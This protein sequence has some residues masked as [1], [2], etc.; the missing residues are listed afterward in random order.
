MRR[1]A[2]R[3]VLCARQRL[4]CA[5]QE[6][7]IQ[8]KAAERALAGSACL[9]ALEG[10]TASVSA[11]VAAPCA[12]AADGGQPRFVLATAASDGQLRLWSAAAGTSAGP[13]ATHADSVVWMAWAPDASALATAGADGTLRLWRIAAEE[14]CA[15]LP[16]QTLEL[17]VSAL[18]S[19]CVAC[20][21][22]RHACAH[23]NCS[24][25]TRGAAHAARSRRMAPGW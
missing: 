2:S 11:L 24:R 22:S 20:T 19:K 1:V 14:A 17:K 25:A 9:A 13:V 21:L 18:H 7:H 23:I 5:A 16:Q 3:V 15:A 12:A 6:A 8:L 10:H 4:T